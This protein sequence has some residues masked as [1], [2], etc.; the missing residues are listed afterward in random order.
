MMTNRELGWA[1]GIWLVGIVALM[2][3]S[4]CRV[5]AEPPP[6]IREMVSRPRQTAPT[7]P[8][9]VMDGGVCQWPEGPSPTLLG[10]LLE[11]LPTEAERQ[12][13]ETQIAR[14]KRDVVTVADPWLVLAVYRYEDLLGV[15]DEARGILGA[16]W[17][18]EA[19][20]RTQ[21]ADGEAIRGDWQDGR[22]MAH[23]PAQLWPWH[24]AWCGLTEAGADDV[25]AALGCY[26]Q[27]VVDRHPKAS[28]CA[29]A[30]RVA[31]ALT[32]NGPRYQREG[33]RAESKH[34]RELM[35]WR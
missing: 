11:E 9:P 1:V 6:I 29:D 12:V 28:R 22:A 32:A 27:R 10:V 13:V 2:M 26:W 18:I 34:W 24:R 19:A 8:R 31:E 14:C 5:R 33:C 20:M 3:W 16:V 23:G 15:P 4:D 30:W 25:F 35:R 21:S 7:M 17:C